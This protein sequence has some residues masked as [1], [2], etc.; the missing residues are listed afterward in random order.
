MKP[1][2]ILSVFLMAISCVNVEAASLKVLLRNGIDMSRPAGSCQ[3]FHVGLIEDDQAFCAITGT[4]GAFSGAKEFG[5]VGL[6]S[7]AWV[8]RGSSCQPGI[9]FQ[10]TCFK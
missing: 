8:F 6:E 9:F 7:G 2:L 10:V 1:S 3:D 5:H 4:G